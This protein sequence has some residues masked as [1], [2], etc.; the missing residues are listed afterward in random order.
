MRVCFDQ[1]DSCSSSSAQTDSW[2]QGASQ[3]TPVYGT[4]V[5]NVT[6][7]PHN[8][9]IDAW[10]PVGVSVPTVLWISNLTSGADPTPVIVPSSWLSTTPA[11]LPAGWS[12]SGGSYNAAWT[13]LVDDGTQVVLLAGNGSTADFF[14]TGTGTAETFQPPP[15][16]TDLLTRSGDGT[17]QLSNRVGDVY[18]FNAAG[19]VASITTA[20][21]AGA[22]GGATPA[23]LGYTYSGSPLELTAI[24]DPVSAD[25]PP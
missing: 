1:A 7:G 19:M 11:A 14:G 22:S 5:Q 6:P 17:L 23:V 24:T 4:T 18:T 15:G 8:V 9:T 21:Q 25:P 2:T 3:N 20:E 12:L 10:V 13:G 16:D